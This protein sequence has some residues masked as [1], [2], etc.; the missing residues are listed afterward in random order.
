MRYALFSLLLS[1]PV[2]L[3]AKPPAEPAPAAPPMNE[4]AGRVQSVDSGD[5]TLRILTESGFLVTFAYTR[6]TAFKGVGLPKSVEDL[7]YE[8]L[9]TVRYQGKALVAREIEKR[10]LASVPAVP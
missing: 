1:L 10:S 4:I 5:Q 8:E 7:K 2:L 6:D 3:H 9:V